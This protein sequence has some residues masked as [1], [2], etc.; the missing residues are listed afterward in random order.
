M[1]TLNVDALVGVS[2][3]N[4]IT[5]RG[6]GTATTSLQQ[7]LAK[8]WQIASPS[9]VVTDGFNTSSNNDNGTGDHTFNILNNMS[10]GNYAINATSSQ[11]SNAVPVMS[12]NPTNNT[13]S[14]SVFRLQIA[15]T[16]SGGAYEHLDKVSYCSIHGDLA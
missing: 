14:S 11:V 7:G 4:A 15:L 16:T 3:A 6:E 2:S 9:A 10:S 12:C 1:S 8:A 5:V 13:N